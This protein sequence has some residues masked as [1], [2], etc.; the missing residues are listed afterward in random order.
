MEVAEQRAVVRADVDDQ[1]LL[2]EREQ[3]HH[4]AIQLGEV[5]AQDPGRAA[6]V[7]VVRREEDGRIDD[8]AELHQLALR[9]VQELG[10]IRRLLVRPRAD[11]VHRVDR[12]QEAEEQDR[13]QVGRAAHLA[14][15]DED[16]AA[17]SGGF[18]DRIRSLG[19]GRSA[20]SGVNRVAVPGD[21]FRDS[22]LDTR[23]GCESQR[24]ELC[25]VGAA[26]GVLPGKSLPGTMSI[27]RPKQ[28]ATRWATFAIVT[29]PGT[30]M[31]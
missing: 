14:A 7:G 5:L 27:S 22:G 4:L 2:P 16:A 25:D 20:L 24:L 1:I 15:L 10:R 11:R 8:Q 12:R 26:P 3:L 30:P 28:A 17:G 6:G 9:A 19:H 18:L 23:H 13:T 31:W 21:G 29:S